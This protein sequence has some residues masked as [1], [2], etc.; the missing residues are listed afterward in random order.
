MVGL[1]MVS[2][3]AG[4]T[5]PLTPEQRVQFIKAD[6]I[7]TSEAN[8]AVE[9]YISKTFKDP[10]SVRDLKVGVPRLAHVAAGG[11]D[12]LWVIPFSCNAKNSFGAYIGNREVLAFY[13]NGSVV[14]GQSEYPLGF[15]EFFNGQTFDPTL[16]GGD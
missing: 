1:G 8:K 6:P 13:S 10:Y 7:T 3:V 12:H 15:W 11:Y 4:C 16:Y 5:T 2:L 9:E 14:G